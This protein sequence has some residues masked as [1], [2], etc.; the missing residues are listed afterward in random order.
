MTLNKNIS[1]VLVTYNSEKIIHSFLLQPQLK[2]NKNI[3]IVDNASKDKTVEAIKELH[4]H[5]NII[6][7]QK[8]IGFGSA[9]NLALQSVTTK[10]ALVINP[11]TLFSKSFFLDLGKSIQKYP[12]AG[13][14]APT[15]LNDC[16]F[17]NLPNSEFL[18]PK[19]KNTYLSDK[20]ANFIS[21]ACFLIRPLLFDNK[22]I[23]DENI[24]MFYEDND[25]SKRVSKLKLDMIILGDCFIYHK[26][27]QSSSPSNFITALK[28]FHYGWSE[29]YYISKYNL[30]LISYALNFLSILNYIK[31]IFIYSIT[32]NT[33]RLKPCL[34]RLKGKINFVIG[35]K[36]QSIR[37]DF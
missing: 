35:K 18:K 29:S 31:R 19:N 27:E 16:D 37:E 12:Y 22:K 10:Y 8:N 32:F 13:L 5:V 36:S 21:G 23:F 25:L 11:D 20:K 2:N 24:F 33:K 34:F 4:S 30:K 26:G 1:I 14:I 28:N 6:I 3:F 15:T 7:S 17:I 9:I